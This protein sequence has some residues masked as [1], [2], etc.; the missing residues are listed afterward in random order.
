M[1]YPVGGLSVGIPVGGFF[2]GFPVI[3]PQ[4]PQVALQTSLTRSR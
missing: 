3:P 1:G 2:V 4:K